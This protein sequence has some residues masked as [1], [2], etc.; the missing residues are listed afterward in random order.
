MAA[1]VPV[2]L[3]VG[4]PVLELALGGSSEVVPVAAQLVLDQR[5]M[6]STERAPLVA[7]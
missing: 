3:L 4:Q 7:A 1:T 6:P 2:A 5:R